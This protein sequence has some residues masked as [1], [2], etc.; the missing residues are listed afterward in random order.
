MEHDVCADVAS[1][2]NRPTV[3][4]LSSNCPQQPATKIPFNDSLKMVG[5]RQTDAVLVDET[6]RDVGVR[7]ATPTNNSS[8]A[9][10]YG[11]RIIQKELQ[12]ACV[13][14][15]VLSVFFWPA[16]NLHH[17]G[18]IGEW[19]A[20]CAQLVSFHTT[21]G[22]ALSVAPL[23][24]VARILVEEGCQWTLYWA[25]KLSQDAKTECCIY[26]CPPAAVVGLPSKRPR[27]NYQKLASDQKPEFSLACGLW[28]GHL[29]VGGDSKGLS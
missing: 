14:N 8:C 12:L 11:S 6:W 22:S 13:S 3:A 16:S 15:A 27:I 29:P 20:W 9:Y 25:P 21:G 10:L 28:D 1:L 26:R 19:C 7:Q 17:D 5:N 2:G 23:L 18:T 4:L 24:T